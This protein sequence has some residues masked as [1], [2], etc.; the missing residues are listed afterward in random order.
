L[1]GIDGAN[2]RELRSSSS[3][4]GSNLGVKPGNGFDVVVEDVRPR[5]EDGCKGRAVPLE[6]RDEHLDCGLRD[7]AADLADGRCK[8]SRASVRE[9]VAGDGGDHHVFQAHA[10]GGGGHAARFV[11]I[12]RLGRAGAHRTEAAV[13]GAAFAHDQESR[14]AV[15]EALPD[16]RALGLLADGVQPAG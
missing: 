2:E 12:E 7:P 1:A 8:V 11:R 16:V 3:D 10:F 9:V 5:A 13:A 6:I 14:R 4:L 15:G